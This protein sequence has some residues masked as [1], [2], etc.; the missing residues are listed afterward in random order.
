MTV[1][2]KKLLTLLRKH[3]KNTKTILTYGNDFEL[4]IAV[5]LSAQCTDIAVNKVTDKLFPK[6]R[7]MKLSSPEY[8][9][10][11][12]K[13]TPEIQEMINFALVDRA[14][15]GQD[16][17]STG[18]FN[19]KAKSVQEA[20]KTILEKF[21]G[22]LP[23]TLAE[24]TTIPG[25]ARKT[26]NVV[27]GNAFGIVEGIAVD[28]HVKKQSQRFGLTTNTDPNKI[29]QD[30]MKQFDKKDWFE[31]TY[32]LIEHGRTIRFKKDLYCEV[33]KANCELE[34][35]AIHTAK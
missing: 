17:K 34:A 2:I 22:K 12:S 7:T 21:D 24:M 20:S 13:P 23:R 28:T 32:L 19:N 27:L 35:L 3:Y 4:L 15:L 14:E 6:F 1:D 11:F 9:K 33:C 31:L 26:G 10:K 5:I 8:A 25:V 30:L 16:I 18:F 29:E